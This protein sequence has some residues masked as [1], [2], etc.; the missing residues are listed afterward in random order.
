MKATASRKDPVATKDPGDRDRILQEPARFIRA[1]GLKA[2]WY[3]AVEAL[4]RL[5]AD[6][7]LPL[8]GNIAFR[9]LLSA[10][11]FLIFMSSLAAF[12]GSEKL[13]EGTVLFLFEIAPTE[14]IEPFLPEIRSV[15]TVERGGLLSIGLLLTLWTASGGIDSI[16]V[17]LNRAYDFTERRSTPM[18]Y[19]IYFVFIAAAAVVLI[20]F[21]FLVVLSPVTSYAMARLFPDLP[22]AASAYHLLR[23]P[24][25]LVILTLFLFAAHVFLPAYW[26][27]F[28]DLWVGIALTMALWLALA[29]GYSYYLGNFANYASYYAGLG[30][31]IAG[32]FFLY[33]AAIGL[34]FGGEINRAVRLRR[35]WREAMDRQSGAEAPDV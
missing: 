24:A 4:L 17:G 8:A 12:V 15:L 34:I 28:S 10:F 31:V 33:L 5:W 2:V 13:A 18:L 21:A 16:R 26:R 25:A 27:K 20:L 19:L 22:A 23:W 32:M 11:P 9:A 1:S 30:G 29:W 7:A 35:K 14:I 6:E 3:V